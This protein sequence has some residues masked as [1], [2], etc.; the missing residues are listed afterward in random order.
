MKK[1]YLFTKF[2]LSL[3]LLASCGG[4]GGNSSSHNYQSKKWDGSWHSGVYTPKDSTGEKGDYYIET[5]TG[6]IY[7][8]NENDTWEIVSSLDDLPYVGEAKIYEGYDGNVW[9]N[10]KQTNVNVTPYYENGIVDNTLELMDNEFFLRSEIESKTKVVL[11]NK[12]HSFANKTIYDS[13]EIIEVSTY[14]N[15]SGK[16]DFGKLNLNTKEYTHLATKDVVAGINIVSLDIKLNEYETLVLGGDNTNVNLYKY[17]GVNATDEFGLFSTDLNNLSLS[18]TNEVKDKVVCNV[19][20]NLSTVDEWLLPN[21][22]SYKDDNLLNYKGISYLQAPIVLRNYEMFEGLKL[23][24]LMLGIASLST[25]EK[26]YNFTLSVMSQEY[27]TTG[28][29]EENIINEYTLDLTSY[30]S[31]V[32]SNDVNKWVE[33]DISELNISV[34]ENETLAFGKDTDN[35]MIAIDKSARNTQYPELNFILP[36][37]SSTRVFEQNLLVDISYKTSSTFQEHLDSLKASELAKKYEGKKLSILGD[38]ISTFAGYSNNSEYNTT[39][40]SNAAHY[41]G[42]NYGITSV[43]Q[44][45]WKKLVDYTNMVLHVNNSSAGDSMILKGFERALELDNN[46]GVKP[47]VIVVYFGIN[48]IWRKTIE[49][50]LPLFK[51]NYPKLID[52]I[53]ENYPDA[54]IYALTHVP[55]M[56]RENTLANSELQLYN[57]VIRNSIKSYDNC[58][59]VDYFNAKIITQYNY[60]EYTSDGLHPNVEGMQII[61][62][63]ILDAI[64]QA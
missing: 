20:I 2:L 62:N 19:K 23:S 17:Q 48:D 42:S 54:E 64:Y 14:V 52:L 33:I 46:E 63:C 44:T 31:D 43:N 13:L 61:T 30:L 45:W 6:S 40:S 34:G 36:V 11:M 4:E 50:G 3:L 28:K 57:E 47:D 38:S 18:S 1:N 7:F 24:K 55:Y 51:E 37:I 9:I 56:W 27:I 58:H 5:D 35:V 39:L 16:L 25:L 8:R 12:Y 41:S 22:R 49:D 32:T 15:T 21:S 26:P 60:M 53:V 59:L 10:E 29:I